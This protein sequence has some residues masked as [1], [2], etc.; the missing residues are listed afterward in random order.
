MLLASV[1]FLA[2]LARSAGQLG[3]MA[4]FTDARTTHDVELAARLDP[5]SYRIQMRLASLYSARGNCEGVRRAAGA[6]RA[7]YPA[8]PDPRRLLRN[9]GVRDRG[10]R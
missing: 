6:A 3:A 9:C 4:V 5:G 10:T 8:A 1:V 7:M 2:A